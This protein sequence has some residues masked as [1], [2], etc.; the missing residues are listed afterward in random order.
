MFAGSGCSDWSEKEPETEAGR[1]FRRS[2]RLLTGS[3]FAAVFR[4]GRRFRSGRLE[5]I[6]LANNLDRSRLGLVIS[7]KCGNAVLR[8]RFKRILRELFRLKKGKISRPVDIVI[9]ALPAKKEINTT[10]GKA[11]RN[12]A[13]KKSFL[14]PRFDELES[15]FDRFLAFMP[16][17]PGKRD[18]NRPANRRNDK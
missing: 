9:R 13:N 3:D 2:E 8:N 17:S 4:R 18:H 5:F 15:D 12:R 14:A 16:S 6:F 1:G 11:N 7:R 10:P